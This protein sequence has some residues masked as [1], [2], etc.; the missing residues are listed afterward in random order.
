MIFYDFLFYKGVELGIKTKNYV[1]VP[2]LGGL[3]VVAPVIGF[4]LISVFMALDIFLNYAVMKTVFSINKILL[5]VLF[6]SI[7]AF[8]Y[9]FKSRYKVIIENY[10]KKRQKG[11]I[12]DLHPASIIIPTLL[13][14]AGLIFLL[15]YIASVKKTYG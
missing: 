13:V 10:D 7:L 14:S 8:Y 15:I 2:M 3:A 12:Y 1:D 11:N 5:A 4:N 6:L 9:G